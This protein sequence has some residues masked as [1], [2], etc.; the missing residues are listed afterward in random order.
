MGAIPIVASG[1]SSLINNY[2][3]V[4][5]WQTRTTQNRVRK[6]MRVRLSPRAQNFV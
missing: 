3:R 6:L 2:A 1:K 5:E 4:A